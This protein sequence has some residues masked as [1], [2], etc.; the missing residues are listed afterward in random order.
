MSDR[1][2]LSSKEVGQ[3]INYKKR[4]KRGRDRDPTQEGSLK[5]RSFQTPGNIL[6]AES[7]VSF[8]TT[9]GNLIGRKNK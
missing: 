8:G 5:K 9:E 1:P 6:S 3:N 2:S 7:V 4:D